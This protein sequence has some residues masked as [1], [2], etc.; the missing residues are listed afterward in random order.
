MIQT[1]D[2]LESTQQ[3]IVGKNATACL[4]FDRIQE[5][6]SLDQGGK[7]EVNEQDDFLAAEEESSANIN[8]NHTFSKQVAE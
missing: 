5:T 2:G 3:T 1:E 7:E 4:S 8:L 6:H